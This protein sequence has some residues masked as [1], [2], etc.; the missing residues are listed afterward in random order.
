MA[1]VAAE[2]EAQNEIRRRHPPGDGDLNVAK[3]FRAA[4][5]ARDDHRPIPGA[6]AG[7]VR[8]NDVAVLHEG[9]GV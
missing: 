3:V 2:E 4:G 8:K 6:H 5:L 1:K 7:S 9:I